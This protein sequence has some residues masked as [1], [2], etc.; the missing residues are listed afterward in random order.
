VRY[1]LLIAQIIRNMTRQGVTPIS[2]EVI[3]RMM[4]ELTASCLE[5]G[6]SMLSGVA[7]E[8]LPD[9]TASR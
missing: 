6:G 3:Y 9:Y 8:L 5:N 4:H 7:A 2:L 1:G